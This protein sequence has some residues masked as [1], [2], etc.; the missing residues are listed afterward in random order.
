MLIEIDPSK[1]N[2]GD[3]VLL[4]CKN[5]EQYPEELLPGIYMGVE[6]IVG[7][8]AFHCGSTVLAL[9]P[10]DD[11]TLRDAQMRVITVSKFIISKLEESGGDQT[12]GD[13]KQ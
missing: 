6:V 2:L 5:H 1:L 10:Y 13:T 7:Y 3:K 8:H 9:K 11:G 12:N 4:T